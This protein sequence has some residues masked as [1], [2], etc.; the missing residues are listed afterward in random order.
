M[1]SQQESHDF[2]LDSLKIQNSTNRFASGTL[3][4]T[5][6][7]QSITGTETADMIPVRASLLISALLPPFPCL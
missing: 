3:V 6:H 5:K 1:K 4:T 2:Q 7:D